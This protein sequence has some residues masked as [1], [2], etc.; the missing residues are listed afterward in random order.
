MEGE[1][2]R[3]REGV[4]VNGSSEG[5]QGAEDASADGNPVELI[6]EPQEN[7]RINPRDVT[8][9]FLTTFFTSLIPEMPQ[10]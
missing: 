1:A 10:N 4:E 3:Q 9:T 8:W 2:E 7:A 5:S 6:P